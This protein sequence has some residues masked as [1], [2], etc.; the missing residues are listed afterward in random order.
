ME[1]HLPPMSRC[2]EKLQ[3][4]ICQTRWNPEHVLRYRQNRHMLAPVAQEVPPSVRYKNRTQP[5]LIMD[6]EA[7]AR[8]PKSQQVL[9]T[10]E[11]T[12]T[13]RVH[14]SLEEAPSPRQSPTPGSKKAK[15]CR[16]SVARKLVMFRGVM[17]P[18]QREEAKQEDRKDAA[19]RLPSISPS[20]DR[21]RLKAK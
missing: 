3:S 16:G 7:L 12:G 9:R 5:V 17:V 2:S 15:V 14:T 21:P 19:M 18:F 13:L 4:V 20:P 6:R 10:L 11:S 8:D 1:V